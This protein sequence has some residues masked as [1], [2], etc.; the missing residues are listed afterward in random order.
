MYAG[1]KVGDCWRCWVES[2]LGLNTFHLRTCYH[3]LRDKPDYHAAVLDF[4]SRIVQSEIRNRSL[5]ASLRFS[6]RHYFISLYNL[7]ARLDDP[8]EA[9]AYLGELVGE[10]G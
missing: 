3:P 1:V 2:L 4:E 8:V 7:K 5:T 10:P 9:A 6:R